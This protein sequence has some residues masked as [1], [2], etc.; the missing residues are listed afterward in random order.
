[1]LF[2]TAINISL[3]VALVLAVVSFRD[4]RLNN[5]DTTHAFAAVE[6]Q[7]IM[8]TGLHH[9]GIIYSNLMHERR[10]ARPSAKDN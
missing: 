9:A 2:Q 10:P 8:H 3:T 4:S 1:M 5:V 7:S 6:W